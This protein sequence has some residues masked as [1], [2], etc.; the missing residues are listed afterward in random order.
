MTEK[1]EDIDINR[2]KELIPHRYPMLLVDKLCDIEAGESAVGKK[3]VTANEPFF[4]GHF[5]EKPVMPGVLIV[6]AMAQSAAALV[7]L[8]LGEDAEGKLVYFMS[9]DG[10]KF[11]KPV[12]PGDMLELHVQKEQNRRNIWKFSGKGIVD[13]QVVAEASFKAMIAT[14]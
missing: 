13:G 5:P 7:M 1:I 8:S 2:I 11:R 10:V 6:E 4:Q 9:I 12:E 14:D 3:G